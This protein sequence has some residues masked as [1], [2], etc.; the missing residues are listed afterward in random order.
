VP[1]SSYRLPLHL[2]QQ[3]D[4]APQQFVPFLVN[5]QRGNEVQHLLLVAEV[6]KVENLPLLI[7][8]GRKVLKLSL[9]SQ[10]KEGNVPVP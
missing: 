2:F 1:F 9:S 6:Q 3:P 8:T 7:A 4:I 10:P 5:E